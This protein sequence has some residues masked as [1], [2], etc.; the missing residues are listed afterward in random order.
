MVK[1][2]GKKKESK[3]SAGGL[4]AEGLKKRWNLCQFLLL[5]FYIP[6]FGNAFWSEV[7]K[8]KKKTVKKKKKNDNQGSIID[9]DFEVGRGS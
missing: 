2:F 5:F 8:E 1:D 6:I 9:R 7:C 4:E 3:T